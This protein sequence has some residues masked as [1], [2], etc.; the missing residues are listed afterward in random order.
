MSHGVVDTTACCASCGISEIDD[1]KLMPCDDCDLVKYCSDDCREL[2]RPEHQ[3]DC[4]KRAAKLRDELLFKQPESSHWGDCPICCLPLSLDQQKSILMP[5]CS[6]IFCKGCVY[7]NQKREGEMRRAPSCPFC[8]E[9]LP[10]TDEEKNKQMMKRVEANDPIAL[11]HKGIEQYKKGH[12]SSAFEYFTKAAELG[13]V[14]AHFRLSFLYQD[15]VRV[16]DGVE[17][18]KEKE[19]D[20]L[21]EAAIAGHPKARYNLGCEE[22]NNGNAER[23]VKHWM[24]SA[25]QAEDRSM[26][27]L[28]DLF[29]GGHVSKEDLTSALRAYQTAV[30]ATKSP[31]REAAEVFY[32]ENNLR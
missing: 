7:A 3:E 19:I 31:Q 10:N 5:C 2:H 16:G 17:Q 26:K 18:N 12:Y 23:A 32:R 1:I 30:N 28:M 27:P 25:T 20:H 9:P 6:K 22:Y 15:R 8:R 14:E 21:E 4:K 11:C 13:D 29:K 24:I